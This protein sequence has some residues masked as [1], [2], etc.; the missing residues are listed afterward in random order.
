MVQDCFLL[1]ED[2]ESICVAMENYPTM[3]IFMSR[4]D[5][6]DTNKR[7]RA[8]NSNNEKGKSILNTKDASCLA[9]VNY[10]REGTNTQVLWFATTRGKNP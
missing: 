4:D 1:E 8:R 6:V 3:A 7:K 10:F 5:R 2:H 9:A